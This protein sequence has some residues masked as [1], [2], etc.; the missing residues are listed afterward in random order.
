MGVIS[1]LYRFLILNEINM[2][3]FI[4]FII[5]FV[6]LP[7]GVLFAQSFV[8]EDNPKSFQKG[9]NL[10]TMDYYG[11][12][13]RTEA[14]KYA[15]IFDK[16]AQRY[17]GGDIYGNASSMLDFTEAMDSMYDVNEGGHLGGQSF[18]VYLE[19]DLHGMIGDIVHGGL[20]DSVNKINLSAGWNFISNIEEFQGK[21]FNDFKGTCSVE[22][23]F[24]YDNARGKWFDVSSLI[25]ENS[26][27]EGVDGIGIGLAVN[28]TQNCTFAL[29]EEFI[30]PP[31][32]TPSSFICPSCVDGGTKYDGGTREEY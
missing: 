23:A 25:S 21:N 12:L 9:W 6:L 27:P 30:A 14:L 18:F 24:A 29:V 4:G 20:E 7:A 11:P 2:K 13:L 15:Y 19:H 22:R 28:V 10:I 3:K 17:V 16:T 1:F 31:L 5:A 26:F 32:P 8:L